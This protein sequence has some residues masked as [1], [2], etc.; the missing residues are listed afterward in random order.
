MASHF[1]AG[2]QRYVVDL[3]YAQLRAISS[4]LGGKALDVSTMLKAVYLDLETFVQCVLPALRTSAGP[5]ASLDDF[6]ADA[7]ELL[8]EAF[9]EEYMRFFPAAVRPEIRSIVSNALAASRQT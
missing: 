4:G 9:L 8:R 1:Q 2:A 6:G 7:I 5:V 3:T